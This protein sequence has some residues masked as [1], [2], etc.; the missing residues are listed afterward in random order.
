MSEM[1]STKLQHIMKVSWEAEQMPGWEDSLSKILDETRK[2]FKMK[3]KNNAQKNMETILLEDTKSTI[4]EE[5]S[6]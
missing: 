2:E 4:E 1:K 5:F 6:M 3:N